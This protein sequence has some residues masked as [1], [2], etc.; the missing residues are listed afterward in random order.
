[1]LDGSKPRRSYY[2]AHELDR[3]GSHAEEMSNIHGKENWKTSFY[4]QHAFGS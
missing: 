4:K 1:M 3:T 2:D